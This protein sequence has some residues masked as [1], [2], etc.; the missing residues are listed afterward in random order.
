[1]RNVTMRDI[2]RR[3]G[4][5]AVTV[6][7]ALS[8]RS[9]VSEAMRRRI[10]AAARDMGYVN[11]NQA[12]Q[13]LSRG[14][15][16]GILIPDQY[17]AP[18]S[19]Y[20]MLYKLLVHAL[21]DSGHFSVLELVSEEMERTLTLPRLLRSGRVDAVILLGQP[22]RAYTR[23]IAEGPVPAVF[24]DFYD[25][26]AG[27]DAVVGDNAYGCY[28]LTS[29][30]IKNGHRHIGFVGNRRA[31]SSIMDRYLGFYRAMLLH[32]LPIREDW[33]L[34]D[35][36]ETG[37]LLPL[38]LPPELPTA[39]VC[40]CDLVA[41]ETIRQLRLRGIRVPEDISVVGFDDFSAGAEEAPALSSF[42]VDVTAMA[43]MA[44]KLVADRCSGTQK[45]FGRV[46]VGGH[47]VYRDSDLPLNAPET[48]PPGPAPGQQP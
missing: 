38:Q 4:V 31:T 36:D 14:L 30:L 35:R 34:P 24:L 37:H 6:S 3:V 15:D 19:F 33:I 39:L 12:R 17:F 47:P 46:V 7:K 25:E 32:D 1:M 27:A 42:H 9:G 26:S 5:S 23:L 48:T 22:S 28:R 29:H 44:V 11:P 18:E 13:E 10:V 20:A 45:P 16:V 2:G 40:N 21:T 41:R 43:Q 8:G